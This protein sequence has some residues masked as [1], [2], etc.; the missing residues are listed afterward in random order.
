MVV[1][2]H[3]KQDTYLEGNKLGDYLRKIFMKRLSKFWLNATT[4]IAISDEVKENW[5]SKLNSSIE[6]RVIPYW[7]NKYSFNLEKSD[8]VPW[9]IN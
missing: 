3:G 7:V 6:S 4:V 8:W 9:K 1:S 5:I 2:V